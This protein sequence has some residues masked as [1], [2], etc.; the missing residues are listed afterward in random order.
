MGLEYRIGQEP[1]QAIHYSA[2]SIKR[3]PIMPQD[4]FNLTKNNAIEPN[5]GA[6]AK[7]IRAVW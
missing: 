5:T 2:F 3:L 4:Y 6:M 7:D 1:I